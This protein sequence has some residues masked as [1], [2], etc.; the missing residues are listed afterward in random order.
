MMEAHESQLEW[1]GQRSEGRNEI[2]EELKAVSRFRG[3][4][5]GVQ[6]AEAFRVCP[7]AP[8]ITPYRVLP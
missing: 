3:V 5:C 2:V 4:Q 8:R 6:Y 1:I 7:T